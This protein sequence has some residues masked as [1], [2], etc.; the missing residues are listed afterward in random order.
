MFPSTP[1]LDDFNRANEGPPPSASWAQIPGEIRGLAVITLQCAPD[2]PPPFNSGTAY[3]LAVSGP[4]VEWYYTIA[5][6]AD[7]NED[8]LIVDA[9]PAFPDDTGFA[10]GVRR[11]DTEGDILRIVDQVAASTLVSIPITFV[12]GDSFGIRVRGM[13]VEGYQKHVAGTW[14]LVASGTAITTP[15]AGNVLLYSI[16]N[17]A[18][19]DFGGG[20]YVAP[21]V[22]PACDEVSWSNIL[23]DF[24]RADE[25]PPPSANWTGRGGGLVV[26]TNE[27]AADVGEGLGIGTYNGLIT[28]GQI[29]AQLTVLPNDTSSADVFARFIDWD[30][31]LDLKIMRND[32][33]GDTVELFELTGGLSTLDT[34][35]YSIVLQAGDSFG[36]KLNGITVEIWRKP[37]GGS[38]VP[39]GGGATIEREGYPGFGLLDTTGRWDN[40]GGCVSAETPLPPPPPPIPQTASAVITSAIGF[41]RGL[42][43]MSLVDDRFSIQADFVPPGIAMTPSFAPGGML[44]QYGGAELVGIKF[45][46]R[47]LTFTVQVKGTSEADVKCGIAD[48]QGFL[49]AAGDEDEPTYLS[50]KS[51]PNLLLSP[52]WGQHGAAYLY[53]ILTA[54]VVIGPLYGSAKLRPCAV[55][56]TV[57]L[58][59]KPFAEGMLQKVCNA[60]GGVYEDTFFAPAGNSRGVVVCPGI[61]NYFTNPIFG[62]GTW[63]TDWT[64]DGGIVAA[65]VTDKIIM[66]FGDCVARLTMISPVDST[67]YQGVT[68]GST[69]AHV[70]SCYIR[71]PSGAA[72]VAT[73]TFDLLYGSSTY[74]PTLV[75]VGNGW[76]LAYAIVTGIAALTDAGIRVNNY[77][78]VYVTGFQ[79]EVSVGSVPTL[80]AWGDLYGCAWSSTPHGSTT[81]RM[82]GALV[83]TLDSDCFNPGA[84]SIAMVWRAGVADTYSNRMTF[85]ACNTGLSAHIEDGTL[86]FTDG[87]LTAFVVGLS[88]DIGDTFVF[89][90]TWSSAGLQVFVNGALAATVDTFVPSSPTLLY[91]GTDAASSTGLRGNIQSFSI[92]GAALSAAECAADYSNVSPIVAGERELEPIPFLWTD[93]GDG[94]LEAGYDT[95]HCNVGIVDGVPGSTP[96]KTVIG[97]VSSIGSYASTFFLSAPTYSR[98]KS[99]PVGSLFLDESG[100]AD[101]NCFGG[102]YKESAAIGSTGLQINTTTALSKQLFDALMG[103]EVI[104][105]V[106]LLDNGAG[107]QL[108]ARFVIDYTVLATEYRPVSSAGFFYFIKAPGIVTPTKVV[109][110]AG[111]IVIPSASSSIK[112]YGKRAVGEPSETVELDSVDL[113]PRP[114][115]MIDILGGGNF[116]YC[117]RRAFVYTAIYEY[118]EDGNVVGDSIEFEPGLVNYFQSICFDHRGSSIAHAMTYTV[119]V[120][121]RYALL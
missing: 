73:T 117:D 65:K 23:D 29:F 28:N 108:Q 7:T 97:A 107:L 68:C 6:L 83:L 30:N 24:N 43:F 76:Y 4:D 33:T 88:F 77:N 120:T 19:D 118:V 87:I 70:L 90:F 55:V 32:A 61:T 119:W 64:A 45:N 8:E 42:S 13:T 78:T 18:I 34:G 12:E 86:C 10:L 100:T 58:V 102:A 56:C 51:N 66:P 17:G 26:D 16:I 116:V 15:V 14:I 59:L 80:L 5:S 25:G 115:C 113:L 75:Y 9:D 54:T 104:C 21:I 105:V 96:A 84:G 82:G 22:I 103:R 109:L 11:N 91:I 53:E 50:Y 106:R 93:G 47:M 67:F 98:L 31:Y 41:V 114:V 110:F 85:F 121:P 49:L 3:W 27:C 44:N 63:N 48:L 35:P 81:S 46:N 1:I 101:A 71:L 95:T 92:Y 111:N 79:F 37:S 69:A 74:A 99:P 112:V 36:L 62:N 94:V 20:N 38:W 89:H 52:I 57:T 72:P 39:L 60:M 2:T 40:F